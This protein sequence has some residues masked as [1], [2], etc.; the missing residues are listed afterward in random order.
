[1]GHLDGPEQD[2]ADQLDQGEEMHLSQGDVP[3][4]DEIRLVFGRHPKQLQ[5]IEELQK[6]REKLPPCD[7][8]KLLVPWRCAGS[9]QDLA[10]REKPWIPPS[11]SWEQ[12]PFSLRSSYSPACPSELPTKQQLFHGI[13]L[14][15]FLGPLSPPAR[16]SSGGRNYLPFDLHSRIFT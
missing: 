15:A 10:C 2:E 14:L 5:A 12:H 6:K 16:I 1:M 13:L 4:V 8:G 11:S 7:C 3:Q 9:H